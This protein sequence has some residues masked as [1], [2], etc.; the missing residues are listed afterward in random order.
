VA[1]EGLVKKTTLLTSIRLNSIEQDKV[2]ILIREKAKREPIDHIERRLWN[3]IERHRDE[4][5]RPPRGRRPQAAG[6]PKE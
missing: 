6:R 5:N 4:L 2:L 3:R 1:R